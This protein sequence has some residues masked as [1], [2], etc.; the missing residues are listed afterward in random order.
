MNSFFGA[1]K[2]N[3]LAFDSQKHKKEGKLSETREP[4]KENVEKEEPCLLQ[5][6]LECLCEREEARKKGT[7]GGTEG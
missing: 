7:I 1:K 2:N 4:S 3:F 6:F 5:T